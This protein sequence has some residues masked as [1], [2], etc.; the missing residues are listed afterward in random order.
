MDKLCYLTGAQYE[1]SRL[2]SYLNW[3]NE[4]FANDDKYDCKLNRKVKLIRRLLTDHTS[5]L[6]V[7]KVPKAPNG[8]V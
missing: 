6:L 1:Y 4:V 8:L 5:I 2:D 3:F 7:V